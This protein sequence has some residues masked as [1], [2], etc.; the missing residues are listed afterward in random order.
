[1]S[2]TSTEKLEK[3]TL[4][5]MNGLLWTY[6]THYKIAEAYEKWAKRGDIATAGGTGVVA[7][8]IIWGQL[9]QSIL[10]AIA[11]VVAFLSW[12]NSTLGLTS[13]SKDHYHAA[14]HYHQLYEE[15]RDFYD[16]ELTAGEAS[17][18]KLKERYEGLISKREQLN[19]NSPRTTNK[20]Y[21]QLDE[22]DVYGTTETTEE[23]VERLKGAS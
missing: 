17:Y 22:E 6:K 4:E 21:G 1:M 7:V 13:K 5:V 20:R 19:L 3:R 2:D 23:E 16:L 12:T 11:L 10:L 9:G 18:D 14:D 15:F 8:A